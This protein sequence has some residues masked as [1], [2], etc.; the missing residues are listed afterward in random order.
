MWQMV[1]SVMEKFKEWKE[2]R[3]GWI[4][5]T[6]SKGVIRKDFTVK[7]TFQKTPGGDEG[8]SMWISGGKEHSRQS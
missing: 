6:F 5:G 1:N 3:K 8:G 4:G 7:S 2:D